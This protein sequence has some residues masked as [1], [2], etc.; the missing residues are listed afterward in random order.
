VR[1]DAA[2]LLHDGGGPTSGRIAAAEEHLRRWLLLDAGRARR[3]AETLARPLGR[4][5][6][7]ASVVGATTVR[8]VLERAPDAVAEHRRLL[9]DPVLPDA[10]RSLTSTQSRR[11]VDGRCPIGDER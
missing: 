3:V 7:V 1:V 9:D 8:A 11:S 6:A 10:V 5:H 4:T 2:L